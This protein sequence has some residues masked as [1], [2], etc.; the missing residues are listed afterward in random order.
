MED[1]CAFSRV[2]VNGLISHRASLPGDTLLTIYSLNEF[3]FAVYT[4]SASSKI[5]RKQAIDEKEISIL[6]TVYP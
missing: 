2:L 6:K 3:H 1:T 5:I 4:N